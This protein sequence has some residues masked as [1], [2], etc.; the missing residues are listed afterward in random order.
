MLSVEPFTH[1]VAPPA[2]GGLAAL[3]ALCHVFSPNLAEAASLVGPG[4]PAQ[5]GPLLQRL[6]Y[7]CPIACDT[8]L[9]F[10]TCLDIFPCLP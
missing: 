9:S 3:L 6:P 2:A 5:V 1:A 4:S 8:N 10:S 7:P